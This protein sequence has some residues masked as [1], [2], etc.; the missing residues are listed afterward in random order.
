M[1]A[2]ILTLTGN[3]VQKI[4]TF[5]SSG[6]FNVPVG[7]TNVVV[8]AIAG[9]GGGATTNSTNTGGDGGDAG[10]HTTRVINVTPDSAVTVTIGTG[11]VGA[12]VGN[13]KGGDGLNTVF[14]TSVW[15]GG[16]GGAVS[17]GVLVPNPYKS[18]GSKGGKG[19]DSTIP[20][21]AENG[22]NFLG[23]GGAAGS[24]G[25]GGAAGRGNG[26]AGGTT[27]GVAAGA[28]SGAGGGAGGFTGGGGAGGS[29]WMRVTWIEIAD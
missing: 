8:E 9:G 26:G 24:R 5:T 1:S 21:T 16:A 28:N 2:A 3:G 11:G 4:E 6:T 27:S 20:F 29:G 15:R 7:V 12:S 22:E 25:G 18:A 19:A 14:L 10:V 17:Q 13:N 23:T